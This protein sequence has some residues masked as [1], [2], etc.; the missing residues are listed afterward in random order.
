MLRPTKFSFAFR[1]LTATTPVGLAV[2]NTASDATAAALAA[3]KVL[4][5][6]RPYPVE[7]ANMASVLATLFAPIYSLQD[8]NKV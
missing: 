8:C 2:G 7:E 6:L 4:P 5:L 3:S 1:G